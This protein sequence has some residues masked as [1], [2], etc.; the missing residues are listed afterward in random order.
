MANDYL[1]NPSNSYFLHP[2]ENLA[3]VLVS[4]IL[5][6][7]NYHSWAR[8]M[9][10][11]LISKNKTAFVDGSLPPPSRTDPMYSTWERYNTMVLSWITRSLSPSIAQSILWNDKASDVWN[12]MQD[13]F[14]QDSHNALE[15]S[16]MSVTLDQHLKLV[17]LIQ[18]Q[19]DMTHKTIDNIAHAVNNVVTPMQQN[20]TIDV[21]NS[22][23]LDNTIGNSVILLNQIAH[24]SWLLDTGATDHFCFSFSLFT[25]YRKIKP[26][27]V[28][29]PDGS[30]VTAAYSGT[31]FS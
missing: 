19:P 22:S 23:V 16:N 9:R 14:S 10:V 17:S 31:N 30:F 11:V 28:K 2:N 24:H 12:D 6:G 15:N 13:R 4:P 21:T 20:A 7:S 25:T 18:E 3:L 1:Q 27:S 8:P 26:I 29:L 5:S